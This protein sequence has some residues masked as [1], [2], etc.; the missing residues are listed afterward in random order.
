MIIPLTKD[1]IRWHNLES[2]ITLCGNRLAQLGAPRGNQCN[3][4]VRLK[5][6][7]QAGFVKVNLSK[8]SFNNDK[9][10]G[11]H[12]QDE[13][14]VYKKAINIFFTDTDR[15]LDK[16]FFGFTSVTVWVKFEKA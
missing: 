11:W 5:N 10:P 8:G 7:R 16:V 14:G 15:Y 13:L 2:T 12:W 6:P 9:Y 4:T 1:V 3:M